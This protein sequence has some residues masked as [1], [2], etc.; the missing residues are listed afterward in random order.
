MQSS[1]LATRAGLECDCRYKI[2]YATESFLF[3]L[4]PH[5]WNGIPKIY[6]GR[7]RGKKQR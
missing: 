6:Q 3:T 7:R 4:G 2:V 1:G 5:F